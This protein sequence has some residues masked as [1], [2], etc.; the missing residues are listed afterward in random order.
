VDFEAINTYADNKIKDEGWKTT[1]KKIVTDCKESVTTAEIDKY[2]KV[3]EEPPC[4][5]KKETCDVK[6]MTY[7][8]CGVTRGFIVS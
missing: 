4:N 7:T 8:G 2:Q 6:F 5:F 1:S 3:V